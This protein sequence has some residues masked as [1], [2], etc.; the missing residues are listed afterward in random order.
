MY[1][2]IVFTS[3]FW[4]RRKK[5]KKKKESWLFTGNTQTLSL[6]L[7]LPPSL[8]VSISLVV[9]L[10]VCLS[11]SHMPYPRTRLSINQKTG[12][13]GSCVPA[14][15]VS[16]SHPPLSPHTHTHQKT[17]A[18]TMPHTTQAG[19]ARTKETGPIKNLGVL[20][21]YTHKMWVPWVLLLLTWKLI[22]SGYQR[23]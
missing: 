16:Y 22:Q 7:C 15:F 21:H 1:T 9:R 23:F 19:A 2:H 10:A 3:F 5:E 14:S 13:H 11:L 6:S 12:V 18:I 20:H 17:D 8:S 4:R